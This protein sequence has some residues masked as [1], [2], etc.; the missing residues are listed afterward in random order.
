RYNY[1][2]I[3]YRLRLDDPRLCLPAP[4]YRVRGSNGV[5]RYLPGG[6]VEAD[7]S[8]GRIEE[9]SFYAVPPGRWREGVIPVYPLKDSGQLVPQPRPVAPGNSSQPLFY[10]LPVQ[11]E[12]SENKLTGTWRCKLKD[13][14]GTEFPFTLELKLEGRQVTGTAGDGIITKG[15]FSGGKL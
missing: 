8:W 12:P 10:A 15:M 11:P 5:V 9:G 6:E 7:S 2:Q 3:M 13:T 1:N 4:V 14:D